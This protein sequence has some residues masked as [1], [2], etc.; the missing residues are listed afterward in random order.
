MS[1]SPVPW[2]PARYWH[3]DGSLRSWGFT[4]ALWTAEDH[5]ATTPA[6][7]SPQ[8]S[9]HLGLGAL[10]P[11]QAEGAS[12]VHAVDLSCAVASTPAP[13]PFLPV[14]QR[15]AQSRCPD[16]TEMYF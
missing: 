4:F 3:R 9:L 15:E 12:L 11:E 1:S 5:K 7:I 16:V 2:F 6:L 13:Y 8:W 10:G 14:S